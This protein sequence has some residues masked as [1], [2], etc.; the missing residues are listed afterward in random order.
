MAAI[1]AE[2]SLGNSDSICAW[3]AGSSVWLLEAEA[4]N[5][6]DGVRM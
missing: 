6:D 2:S 5:D 3:S 1:K 4:D